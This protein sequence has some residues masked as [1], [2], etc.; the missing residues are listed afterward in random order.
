MCVPGRRNRRAAEFCKNNFLG[1]F[2]LSIIISCPSDA[3]FCSGRNVQHMHKVC[4]CVC[5]SN[6]NFLPVFKASLSSSHACDS[7]HVFGSGTELYIVPMYCRMLRT[8]CKEAC[9]IKSLYIQI[10]KELEEK[11]HQISCKIILVMNEYKSSGLQAVFEMMEE[12]FCQSW[13]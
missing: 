9:K 12:H 3:K 11:P 13:V 7:V 10:W 4:F 6:Y 2:F 5:A 8:S 1:F